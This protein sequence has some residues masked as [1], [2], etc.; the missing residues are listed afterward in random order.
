MFFW[1]KVEIGVRKFPTVKTGNL[2][3]HHPQWVNIRT[4]IFFL[5]FVQVAFFGTGK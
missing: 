3:G 5:F 1:P 2:S 4:A